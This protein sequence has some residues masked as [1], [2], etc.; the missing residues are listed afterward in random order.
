MILVSTQHQWHQCNDFAVQFI[1]SCGAMQQQR[2]IPSLACITCSLSSLAAIQDVYNWQL[3][4]SDS[5]ASL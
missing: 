1:V 2:F 3:R 4:G 5:G